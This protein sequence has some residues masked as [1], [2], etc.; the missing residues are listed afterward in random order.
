MAKDTNIRTADGS[1]S[2][3]IPLYAS[4]STYCDTMS[5]VVNYCSSD[6][7]FDLYQPEFNYRTPTP[8]PV[9]AEPVFCSHCRQAIGDDYL[10]AYCGAPQG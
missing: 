6:G 7:A 3:E 8:E 1:A 9:R 2:Y 5:P 10:C 4:A